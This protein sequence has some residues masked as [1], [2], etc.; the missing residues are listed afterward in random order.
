MKHT[1][2]LLPL[3]FS[4]LFFACK[5]ESK[6]GQ[7]QETFK[8][9]VEV[10]LKVY[11]NTYKKL[12][13]IAA[14]AEWKLNTYIVEGDT[15][16][17]YQAQVANE[18]LAEFT[19]SREVIQKARQYLQ[20]PE[21]LT[22]WQIKQLKAILYNAAANP[23]IVD[24]L[25]KEKIKA[26]NEQTRL[27]Y[28]FKYVWKGI[29]ITTNDI[30]EGL[31]KL[32]NLQ[33]RRQLWEVSK[34]VG[35]TLKPGLIRLRE[36]RN[37]TVQALNYS[38][39]FSYQVSEYGMSADEMLNLC[40]QMIKEI[41][42]LYRE[43]HTWARYE[44]AKRY[45]Q[46]VPEYIPAH[47]LPNRWGQ[48]WSSLVDVKGIAIDSALVSKG[49]EWIMKEGENFYVSLGFE[50]LP[51]SFWEKSSLYPLPPD[52]GYKKNNH[53]SAWHIDLDRDVRS[54]M[55]V[56]PNTEWWS[57]VLHE[58]GHIYYYLSY[59]TPEV[60][61]VLR[62]GANRSFHEAMGSLIGLASLQPEFLKNRGL[63]GEVK[64]NQPEMLQL[65][66]ALD[67]VVL[68]P[69]SAGV[70][71]E[72]EYLLYAKNLPP[73][74]WNET[75]WNL[76]KKYQGI[77]PPSPRDENYCDAATK[78]HINDDP[79]QYY[80]YA[81]SNILL[82][83]LHRHIAKNILKQDPHKTNYFGSKPT[84]DFLKSLMKPGATVDW[85]VLLENNLGSQLSAN[86][87]VEYFQPL[88]NWLK[89]QNKDRKHTLPESWND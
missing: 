28:G 4:L 82:F 7:T 21:W 35:K 52:A 12:S 14:E 41:W 72:F 61:Y 10:F 65:K 85:R 51:K 74:Q 68:I 37:K 38:D 54:L 1:I 50:K 88:L 80:D 60:P 45:N 78:T 22:P 73:D 58:L 18:K 32:N 83:Q 62:A 66:E 67:F 25:V 64:I 39:Y 69:W 53:A 42:P 24:S 9:S 13:T 75:W 79:A 23:S 48:D 84:G 27:L 6:T 17:A 3:I 20:H 16:T 5:E 8:D 31:K 34:E 81:L 89:E 46:P 33:E 47:W 2:I 11:N 40:K 49:A 56:E 71:T 59:S 87:M 44:L 86:A 55:S 19:G 26:Q 63:L 29:E 77:V 36:L 30:D 76:V 43:L 15:L 70:M 57:T